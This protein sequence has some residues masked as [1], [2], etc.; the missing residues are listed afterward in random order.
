[1]AGKYRII[2]LVSIDDKLLPHT[3]AKGSPCNP[4]IKSC[5]TS[6]CV[7]V[8]EILPGF[9]SKVV[10]TIWDGEDA[11]HWI[12]L[13]VSIELLPNF[14]TPQHTTNKPLLSTVSGQRVAAVEHDFQNS[15]YCYTTIRV[16][17]F[18]CTDVSLYHGNVQFNGQTTQNHL[19][20]SLSVP[21]HED[22]L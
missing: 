20:S 22:N 19:L 10:F 1:M 7:P 16:Q 3:T 9:A 21:D 11:Q 2:C 18:A 4:S 17:H 15:M 8:V 12:L 6:P 5:F 14:L 13:S